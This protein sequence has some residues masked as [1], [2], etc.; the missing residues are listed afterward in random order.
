MDIKFFKEKLEEGVLEIY[1]KKSINTSDINSFLTIDE[2]G[3]AFLNFQNRVVVSG[4]YDLDLNF[5]FNFNLNSNKISSYIKMNQF[6]Y[7]DYFILENDFIS[8]VD[9]LKEQ[10]NFLFDSFINLNHLKLRRIVNN[11]KF[12]FDEFISENLIDKKKYNGFLLNIK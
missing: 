4:W 1:E 7:E 6:Y 11:T 9:A 3:N 12:R 8:Y 5:M 2:G 10:F